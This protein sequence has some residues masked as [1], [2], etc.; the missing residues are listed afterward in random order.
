MD[1]EDICTCK[2]KADTHTFVSA[3]FHFTGAPGA[4]RSGGIPAGR[5]RAERLRFGDLPGAEGRLLLAERGGQTH[6]PVSN[7]GR[8]FGS[9]LSD[10][11]VC[12]REE[13]PA[14]DWDA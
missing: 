4:G 13:I 7:Y 1:I 3:C 10:W 9:P 8:S 14:P 2:M 6:L 5:N 11:G 12:M